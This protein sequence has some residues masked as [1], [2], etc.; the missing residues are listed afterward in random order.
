MLAVD[1]GLPFLFQAGDLLAQRLIDAIALQGLSQ[2]AQRDLGVGY[3]GKCRLLECVKLGD[4]DV[5]KTHIRV[6]EDSLRGGGEIGIA[7]ADADHQIRL[8]RD[9]VGGQRAC[10]AD[11]AQIERMVVGQ[12]ALAGLRLA[13]GNARLL[14]ERN[15]DPY[16]VWIA[17]CREKGI[18]P[19]LS[20]RWAQSTC[21]LS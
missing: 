7:C 15:L 13:N 12:A 2:L 9:A 1:L 6:L 10:R 4:V 21:T 18:S 11:G 16:A 5:N 19:W 14:D 17:R 3:Q 8:S 20:M